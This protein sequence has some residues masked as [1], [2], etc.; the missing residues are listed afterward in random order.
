MVPD[1]EVA[2]SPNIDVVEQVR[3]TVLQD[4]LQQ[5]VINSMSKRSPAQKV[6]TKFQA[7]GAVPLTMG[8]G[9]TT[10][11]RGLGVMPST[12]E[13]KKP[14]EECGGSGEIHLFSS[15]QKCSSCTPQGD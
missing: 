12:V 9:K 15:T 11:Q 1:W 6:G 10:T 13:E 7:G 3:H 14:C 8:L 4:L 5:G 2:K